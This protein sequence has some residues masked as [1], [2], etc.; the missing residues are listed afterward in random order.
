[1]NTG[2]AWLI[3]MELRFKCTFRWGLFITQ[4][5]NTN[6]FRSN[7]FVA[8]QKYF[9]IIFPMHKNMTH[10]SLI[11]FFNYK[12]EIWHKFKKKNW[13]CSFINKKKFHY[14]IN[15]GFKLQKIMKIAPFFHFEISCSFYKQITDY[16]FFTVRP[17]FY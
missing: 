3:S 5:M 16:F 12:K 1:M 14:T 6:P 4:K 10:I 7:I 11:F 8:V 13:E 2:Y 9:L 17:L 15:R